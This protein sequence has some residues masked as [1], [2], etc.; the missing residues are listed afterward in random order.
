MSV[1]TLP[2]A[3]T[4]AQQ[5]LPHMTA[6]IDRAD[7]SDALFSHMFVSGIFPADVYAQMLENLPDPATYEAKDSKILADG[8]PTRSF[9]QLDREGL[10]A[11]PEH[12]RELWTG[13]VE[14]VRSDAFKFHIFRQLKTDLL[15]RFGVEDVEQIEAATRP[16]LVRDVSGYRIAPHPDTRKKVVT[17]MIYLPADESQND[18][19]T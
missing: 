3:N 6:A 17:M 1:A 11:L 18:L 16:R 4:S 8:S 10:T 9:Y 13:V 2:P 5:M 15:W 7:V 14:A 12:S 19:G